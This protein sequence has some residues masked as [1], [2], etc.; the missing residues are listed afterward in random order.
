MSKKR[1][2]MMAYKRVMGIQLQTHINT[3]NNKRRGEGAKEGRRERRRQKTN[4]EEAW[5]W[6]EPHAY[7]FPHTPNSSSFVT[8][9]KPLT[10][11]VL[12]LL[13][14]QL[15]S[16]TDVLKDSYMLA[17][18]PL[19]SW[20]IS[21][22]RFPLFSTVLF[23]KVVFL[24]E[25]TILVTYI[26]PPYMVTCMERKTQLLMMVVLRKE[27]TPI[28][29]TPPCLQPE[30]KWNDDEDIFIMLTTPVSI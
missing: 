26:T 11:N 13:V 23:T 24:T 8:G 19:F 10:V 1:K 3:K 22:P 17:L 20:Y 28:Y 27:V 7:A 4:L 9:I 15:F 25:K 14:E 18:F 21:L 12:L 16:I 6:I 29:I 30:M 5:M 2:K